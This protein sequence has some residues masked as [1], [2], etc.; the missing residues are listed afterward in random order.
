MKDW[1]EFEMGAVLFPFEKNA[2]SEMEKHNDER[3]Y[4]EQS[5]FTTSVAH[6]RVAKPVHNNNICINCFNCWVYCPDAA[7][8]SRE[9]KLKGV[10]YSHCKGCGVC[11]DV[12]P[13]N[14]KS[15][16]MFEEQIDPAN[17]L[18]QWPQKQEKRKS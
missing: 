12:C 14:P 15:L 1:N 11:V 10:D 7:I 4:T 16:W 3:H 17:A 2:Q 18:T 5:Y 6:W 13:T 9:G 8:L